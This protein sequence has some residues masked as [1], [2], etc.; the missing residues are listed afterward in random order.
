MANFQI[1]ELDIQLAGTQKFNL[2]AFINMPQGVGNPRNIVPPVTGPAQRE[3]W[4]KTGTIT[5]QYKGQVVAN[6]LD[7]SHFGKRDRLYLVMDN[8]DAANPTQNEVAYI[9]CGDTDYPPPYRSPRFY[10]EK[11]GEEVLNLN[12]EDF[13]IEM[14]NA[15]RT[16]GSNPFLFEIAMTLQNTSGHNYSLTSFKLQKDLNRAG[17][18]ALVIQITQNG[19]GPVDNPIGAPA[20]GNKLLL[21]FDRFREKGLPVILTDTALTT[22]SAWANVQIKKMLI[23]IDSF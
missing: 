23:F 20:E 16:E 22:P 9:S 4:I 18:E 7:F 3:L 5:S 6:D 14:F 12:Q 11:A 1:D 15:K 2:T 21:Q 19:V 8:E 17:I 10:D 13:K